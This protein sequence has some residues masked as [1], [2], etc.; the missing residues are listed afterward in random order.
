MIWSN[1]QTL[2]I[3]LSNGWAE[4]VKDNSLVIYYKFD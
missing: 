1:M 3:E 4:N 2:P